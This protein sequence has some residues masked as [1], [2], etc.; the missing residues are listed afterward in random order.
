M[1]RALYSKTP[2]AAEAAAYGLTIEEAS[3]PDVEVWPDNLNAVNL[4]ISVSTQW[5][6]GVSGP[7]GLD[8]AVL[9]YVIER[10]SIDRADY[11]QVFADI[12]VL[13]ESALEIMHADK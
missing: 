2:T 12:R 13:E 7:T 10:A 6:S 4:F 8:Y 11:D 9:P 5:R 3:G 1:A